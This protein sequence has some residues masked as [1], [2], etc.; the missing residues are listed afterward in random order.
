M[1]FLVE[2]GVVRPDGKVRK[3]R[4]DE[5]GRTDSLA[6]DGGNGSDTKH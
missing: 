5:P 1:P 3:S 6:A 4:Y 2:L